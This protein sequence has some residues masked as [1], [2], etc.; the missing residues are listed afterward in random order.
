M[1]FGTA[2]VILWAYTCGSFFVFTKMTHTD[3]TQHNM[4]L[5][6]FSTVVK[7]VLEYSSCGFQSYETILCC[8][9]FNQ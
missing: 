6:L 3:M 9:L 4:F 7:I 5:F 2:L 8:L 1:D